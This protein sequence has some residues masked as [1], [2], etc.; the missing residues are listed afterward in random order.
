MQTWLQVNWRQ[1]DVCWQGTFWPLRLAFSSP[2]HCWSSPCTHI[3]SGKSTQRMLMA[4]LFISIN[5]RV[6]VCNFYCSLRSGLHTLLSLSLYRFK[7]DS[8]QNVIYK[9]A[10]KDIDQT[11]I[12]VTWATLFWNSCV[13]F[14]CWGM[15]LKVRFWNEFPKLNMVCKLVEAIVCD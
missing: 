13:L 7:K 2:S 10:A 8:K 6:F 3:D 15:S 12:T 1:F 11:S 14:V 9:P 4:V 5:W